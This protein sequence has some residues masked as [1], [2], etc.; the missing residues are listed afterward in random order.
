M[1]TQRP[2]D[3][4]ERTQFWVSLLS[5]QQLSGDVPLD[6]ELA[7]TGPGQKK[8]ARGRFPSVIGRRKRVEIISQSFGQIILMRKV[9]ALDAALTTESIGRQKWR[10]GGFREIVFRGSSSNF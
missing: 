1:L 7:V 9:R 6:A 4:R 8:L 10:W 2:S 3:L 5:A